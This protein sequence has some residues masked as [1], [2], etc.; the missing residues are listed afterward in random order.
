MTLCGTEEATAAL[1]ATVLDGDAAAASLLARAVHQDLQ[2]KDEA[3]ESLELTLNPGDLGIWIDPIGNVGGTDV[4]TPA[5]HEH[6]MGQD[7][8]KLVPPLK[9]LESAL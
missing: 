8:I 2:V 4:F 9:Y 3:A 7:R 1:L 5:V 6:P